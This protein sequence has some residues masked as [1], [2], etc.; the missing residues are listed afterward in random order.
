MALKID[1]IEKV[2]VTTTAKDIEVNYRAFMIENLTDGKIVYFKEKSEDGK[3]C[4]A[5]NG[6]A[7]PGVKIFDKVMRAKTLSVIGSDS[8][9][10]RILYVV[11]DE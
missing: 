2:S 3:A 4:T 10:A 5:N 9:D 1:S 6:F 7:I 8:C 11:E